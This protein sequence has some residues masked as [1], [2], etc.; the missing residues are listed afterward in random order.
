[1]LGGS[2]VAA[3]LI[4]V[5]ALQGGVREHREALESLG[6][7]TRRVT[8]PSHLDGLDGV[9]LPGGE[10][11]SM[12]RLA[13][14]S[15]LFPAL[16]QRIRDGLPVFGT[17]AGLILL[18]RTVLDAEALAEHPRVPVLDMAVRRNA[19]GGQLAS[20]V[21]PIVVTG[22]STPVEAVFIRAPQVEQVGHAVEVLAE[23]GGRPVLI[24]QGIV[25]AATFH[26]ELT[27]DTRV[28]AMF[29]ALVGLRD[30]GLRDVG[31]TNAVEPGREARRAGSPG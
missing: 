6:A 15:G 10:S 9:V 29:L 21:A 28:H 7:R 1:M 27:P 23:H 16:E 13:A 30:D 24:R 14:A 3:P 11:T 17:C 18:T 2:G 25:M 19:Y 4:G 8:L 31:L 5:V 12:V 22:E 20:F 26:P